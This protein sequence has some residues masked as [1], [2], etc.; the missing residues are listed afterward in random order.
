LNANFLK[1]YQSIYHP[2]VDFDAG[3]DTLLLMDFTDN[4]LEL[5]GEILSDTALFSDYIAQRLSKAGAR[6]GIGGY[7]EH[8]TVYS[9]SAVFDPERPGGEPRR[10]HLGTDIWGKTGTPVYAPIGGM[11]H[12][13]ANNERYG[14]Y[15]ATIIVLHQLDGIPFYTLYGHLSRR[16][17]DH[18]SAG[19]YVV[20]GQV[21]GHF[22]N[23]EENG[24]WPPH[25]HFQV[26]L[27]MEMKEGDYP[28]VCRYSE[29][30]KY[31]GNCPDPDMILQLDRYIPAL[32]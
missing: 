14:D 8:R 21:I 32:R 4:N 24:H 17:I 16:D 7:G 23:A 12:S 15:G 18:L 2:V 20:R 10:V 25:L 9:R 19:Q 13:F 28:G 26:I 30:E 1:K 29:K 6:Y 27:D 3:S 22:G 31:L 11:V 5:S